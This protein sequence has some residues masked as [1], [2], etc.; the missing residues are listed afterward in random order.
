MSFCCG[1]SMIG[2]IGTLKHV[3]THIHNVP[4]VFCPVCHKVEVHYR[5]INE[6]EI[7][8][9]YAHGDGASELDF[10]EYVNKEAGGKWFENC[11][12]HDHEDPLDVVYTQI[13]MALDLWSVAKQLNDT[14]WQEQ[15]V[16]RLRVLSSRRD[17]LVRKRVA[18]KAV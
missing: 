4:L 16:S 6:Y 5:A 12:N 3:D 2:T 17:K 11:V 1:A 8:A 14:Q 9:E 18:G 13:D 7:L 10:L 15:L